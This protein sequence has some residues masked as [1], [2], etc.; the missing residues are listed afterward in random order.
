MLLNQSRSTVTVFLYLSFYVY[1]RFAWIMGVGLAL[2]IQSKLRNSVPRRS[3]FVS[4]LLR[5]LILI[6]LGLVLNSFKNNNIL[7]LRIP[8]V[9]QR[10]GV[11]F[12]IVGTLEA[13][14][15]RPENLSTIIVSSHFKFVYIHNYHVHNTHWIPLIVVWS[16]EEKNN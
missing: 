3:I 2:S 16:F 10:L 5:S 14:F 9:L 1:S 6:S 15:L 13:C 11:S 8:G 12:F 7:K 4:V